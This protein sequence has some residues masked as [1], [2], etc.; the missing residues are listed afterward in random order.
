[1]LL[2]HHT[3]SHL[4]A[5]YRVKFLYREENSNIVTYINQRGSIKGLL[6]KFTRRW[7]FEK[8]IIRILVY[9]SPSY[10][11][12]NIYILESNFNIYIL[13][14]VLFLVLI[15]HLIVVNLIKIVTI[16]SISIPIITKNSKIIWI[17]C[18]FTIVV[19]K[20]SNLKS[21]WLYYSEIFL[22]CEY[23]LLCYVRSQNTGNYSE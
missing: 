22:K 14:N 20:E 7:K 9:L 18:T 6:N 19:Y 5:Y 1:M 12:Q 16:V 11:I 23:Y 2:Y 17:F 21:V 15:V 8:T 3:V 13:A 10:Y 4:I